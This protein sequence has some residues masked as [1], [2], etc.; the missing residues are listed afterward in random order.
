[1]SEPLNVENVWILLSALLISLACGQVGIF[2]L[3]KRMSLMGDA[4]SHSVLPGIVLSYL[5]LSSRS[6]SAMLFGAIASGLLTAILV[7]GIRERSRL[8]QDAAIAVS[9]GSLFAVGLVL[10][11]LFGQ[12]V[13][14]DLDCV[15]FGE[16]AYLPFGP[17]T[18]VLGLEVPKAFVELL[19]MVLGLGLSLKIL[20]RAFFL[21]AFDAAF[22]QINLRGSPRLMHYIF[23]LLV[24]SVIV[25]SLESVGVILVIGQMILPAVSAKLLARRIPGM[26]AISTL[27][28][29]FSVGIG[30][31]LADFFDLN[32]ASCFVLAGSGF[33]CACLLLK[34]IRDFRRYPGPKNKWEEPNE[35]SPSPCA[36]ARGVH[37]AH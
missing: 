24:A 11:S 12:R 6:A 13:D 5:L 34:I 18:S 20:S 10:V 23:S 14:L 2:L 33:F 7:D 22:A 17:Q 15:L 4:I 37:R 31:L 9:F 3:L 29:F 30:F 36:A 16:I 26:F 21:S 1:M 32:F 19:F 25:F 8:K 27:Y 28:A 35:S